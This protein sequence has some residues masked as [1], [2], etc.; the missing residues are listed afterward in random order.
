MERMTKIMA[1]D[2]PQPKHETI[3]TGSRKMEVDRCVII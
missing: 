1:S 3:E 2:R